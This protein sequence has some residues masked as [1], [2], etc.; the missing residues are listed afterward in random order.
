MTE[1]NTIIFA[2]GQMIENLKELKSIAANKHMK[3]IINEDKAVLVK[4]SSRD[5]ND[6]DKDNGCQ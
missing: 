2:D 6:G 4:I 5:E 3:I 1:R